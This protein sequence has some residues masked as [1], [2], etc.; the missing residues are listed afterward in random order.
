M[1]RES[2]DAGRAFPQDEH[3]L[4][5]GVHSTELQL[6]APRCEPGTESGA[7]EENIETVA[8][9]GLELPLSHLAETLEQDKKRRR[10]RGGRQQ[11]MTS[12]QQKA[13]RKARDDK[14][15]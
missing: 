9:L 5:N 15:E 11:K 6:E 2:N 14:L 1:V 13:H 4:T 7:A 8:A 12:D 10:P 3:I